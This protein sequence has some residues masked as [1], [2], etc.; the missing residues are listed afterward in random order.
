MSGFR[1]ATARAMHAPTDSPT[2]Y[3]GLSDA[4]ELSDFT[5][6]STS[7]TSPALFDNVFGDYISRK[8]NFKSCMFQ[9]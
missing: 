1:T 5:V 8:F 4:L 6:V 2:R 9:A 3:T 7:S